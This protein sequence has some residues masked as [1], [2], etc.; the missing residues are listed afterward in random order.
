MKETAEC[1]SC[2]KERGAPIVSGMAARIL[3][4]GG[5]CVLQAKR[6]T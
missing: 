6:Y 3:A 4:E 2:R 1:A 5:H